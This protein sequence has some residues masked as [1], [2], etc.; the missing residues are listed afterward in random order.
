MCSDRS[1]KLFERLVWKKNTLLSLKQSFFQDHE[2]VYDLSRHLFIGK[3]FNIENATNF[4]VCLKL[5]PNYFM[6]MIFQ[7]SILFID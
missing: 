7:I 2:A 6:Y 5:S 4:K 3:K 1:K